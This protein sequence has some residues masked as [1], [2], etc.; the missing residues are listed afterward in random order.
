MATRYKIRAPDAETYE[1]MRRRVEARVRVFVASEKRRT[2]STEELP[3][4]LLE[5]VRR[6]G[7]EVTPEI[8][9]DLEQPEA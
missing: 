5:E 8:Q 7:C 1:E 2:L 4:D 9:Y 6:R 3:R